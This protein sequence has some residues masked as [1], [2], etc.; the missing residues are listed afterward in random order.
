MVRLKSG[1]DRKSMRVSDLVST[2]QGC[3]DSTHVTRSL[4]SQTLDGQSHGQSG[5]V[6]SPHF[7]TSSLRRKHPRNLSW[8]VNQE[9]ASEDPRRLTSVTVGHPSTQSLLLPD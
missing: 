1:D 3:R 9:V 2:V 7:K 8:M 5:T 6:E 4:S